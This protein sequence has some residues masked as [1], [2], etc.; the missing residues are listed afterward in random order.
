MRAGAGV[1]VQRSSKPLERLASAPRTRPLNG[2]VR[3]AARA[4]GYLL[5][6]LLLQACKLDPPKAAAPVSP[7]TA[8]TT[9]VSELLKIPPT[10]KPTPASISGEISPPLLL[11]DVQPQWKKLGRKHRVF[12]PNIIRAVVDESGRVAEAKGARCGD[13]EICD[14]IVEAVRQWRYQPAT[15][16][17]T[18]VPVELFVVVRISP[19]EDHDESGGST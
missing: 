17:G 10:P 1:R 3:C 19:G 2:G 5:T 4:I 13:S 18:P 16:K 6:F 12:G 9:S 15:R 7:A 11:E 14:V 8:P